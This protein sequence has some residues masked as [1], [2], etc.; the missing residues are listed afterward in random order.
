GQ[1]STNVNDISVRLCRA[2]SAFGFHAFRFD[3]HGAGE[4]GGHSD[5]FHLAEPFT[6][7]LEGAIR[8]LR[9]RGVTRFVLVGSCFG[10]RTVLAAAPSVVGLLSV[11]LLCPPVRDIA[12]GERMAAELTTRDYVRRAV[13]PRTLAKLMSADGRRIY[14]KLAKA[15]VRH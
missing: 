5:R 15:K 12:M 8:C 6:L 13:K 11:I 10:A 2:V 1:L 3:Y 7:D 14:T 9:N 4:S